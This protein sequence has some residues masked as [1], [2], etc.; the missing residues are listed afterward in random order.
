MLEVPPAC[1]SL[2]PQLGGHGVFCSAPSRGVLA[3]PQLL[4]VCPV[5]SPLP[6]GPWVLAEPATGRREGSGRAQPGS[7]PCR[8]GAWAGSSPAPGAVDTNP[9]KPRAQPWGL[10]PPWGWC[11]R[12]GG[13]TPDS[14]EGAEGRAG[15]Q[16]TLLRC[17]R[18]SEEGRRQAG[19]REPPQRLSRASDS[20]VVPPP[21]PPSAS[22]GPRSQCSGP[23]SPPVQRLS[24]ASVSVLGSPH[25][26]PLLDLSQWSAP[27]P[28]RPAPLRGHGLS[29]RGGVGV[30]PL[31][32]PRGS[33]A[34]ALGPSRPGPKGPQPPSASA[35]PSAGPCAIGLRNG[36]SP[37]LL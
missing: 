31:R 4:C 26:A 30:S 8:V 2:G 14:R 1:G 20:V 3:T 35:L 12:P 18:L 33:R 21:A 34:R 7:A 37:A 5:A 19:H 10:H 17:V 13:R 23:P 36:P 6:W 27:H 24:W 16:T 28:P 25:P 22:P 32:C 11:L 9:R 15:V 29:G